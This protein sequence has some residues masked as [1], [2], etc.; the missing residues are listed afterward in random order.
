M[1]DIR[2]V[3]GGDG[4]EP[5][6]IRGRKEGDAVLRVNLRAGQYVDSIGIV[7]TSGIEVTPGGGGGDP[8]GLILDAQNAEYIARVDGRA[9]IYVDYLRVTTNRGRWVGGGGDGGGD[10]S[11]VAPQGMQIIGFHGAAGSY[12]DSLGVILAPAPTP[13][14][15]GGV[16]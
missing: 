4:G 16:G 14:I 13:P 7:Y 2:G 3:V 6:V 10:F 12:V 9:G 5:Y 15:H 1:T 11:F 8:A